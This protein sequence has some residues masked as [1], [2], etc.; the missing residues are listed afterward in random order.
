V[1]RVSLTLAL[2][3]LGALSLSGDSGARA[4]DEAPVQPA[5]PSDPAE[6]AEPVEP[7]GPAEPEDGTGGAADRPGRD[8]AT[9]SDPEAVALLRRAAARQGGAELEVQSFRA[10]FG[11]VKMVRERVR[12]DGSVLRTQ[13]E[14]D[15]PGMLVDWKQGSLRTNWSFDGTRT[16]RAWNAPRK[17]AW[18]VTGEETR[19]RL[20]SPERDAQDV[21]QLEQ[22]REIVGTLLDL[23]LLGRMLD[24]GSVWTRVPEERLAPYERYPGVAL[25]RRPA[26]PAR[27]VEF[28]VW[29]DPESLDPRAAVVPPSEPGASILHYELRYHATLPPVDGAE[30]RFPFEVKVREQRVVEQEPMPILEVS[31]RRLVVNQVRDDVFTRL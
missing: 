11:R 20:L 29:I 9:A 8:R 7:A 19:L 14:S 12:E 27:Q 15:P 30:L 1:Q 16:V 26:D 28:T 18:I 25:H 24:D 3:A 23:A 4:E 10:E 31:V 22:H 5:E 17:T 6:P 2:V 13:V 21:E